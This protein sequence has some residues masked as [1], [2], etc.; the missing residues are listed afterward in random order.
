MNEVMQRINLAAWPI[1]VKLL[2]G[3]MLVGL[4]PVI[5][6]MIFTLT[7]IEEVGTQ[8]IESFLTET[9]GQAPAQTATLLEAHQLADTIGDRHEAVRALV[10]LGYSALTWIQP[11]TA[12]RYTSMAID[13]AEEHQVDRADRAVTL[14]TDDQLGRVGHDVGA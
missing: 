5:L 11:A 14:L 6:L 1:W 4:I 9:A 12:W 8:N 7:S 3:F 10:N 13:Y 2:V